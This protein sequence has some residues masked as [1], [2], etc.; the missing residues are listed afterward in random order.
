MSEGFRA[1]Y[2]AHERFQHSAI[3]QDMKLELERWLLGVQ[4]R[5]EVEDDTFELYRLQGNAK[6]CRYFMQLPERI[7]EQYEA[8]MA[9]AVDQINNDLEEDDEDE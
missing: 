3:W 7:V 9:S 8:D 4:E 5:M 6:A 1:G 2:E